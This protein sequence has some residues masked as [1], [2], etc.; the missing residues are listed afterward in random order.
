MSITVKS[1]GDRF[2]G[3][4]YSDWRGRRD[5]QRQRAGRVPHAPTQRDEDGF[6]VR[7]ALDARQP[8]RSPVRHQLQR[9]RPALEAEGVVL[10]QLSPER[11]VQ[12]HARHRRARALEADQQLHLQGHLPAQSQQ[13]GHR[14]PEQAREAAGDCATS[15][16]RRRSRR[17]ATRRRATTRGRSSG[18]ACSAAA[19]S[20]TCSPATGTTSSRC[21][22]PTTTGFT[23]DRGARAASTPRPTSVRRRRP[24]LATRIRS[25][26]SR[27]STSSLSYFKDGWDGSHDF[28]FGY[29]WK[30][31]RRNLFHD[32]PFDIFYRDLNSAR[33]SSSS[34]TTRRPRRSTTSSTT[35]AGSA[36]PGS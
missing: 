12:V 2:T 8:D 17:R 6:F 22:R 33:E 4:W 14:L 3:N 29:D 5:D 36:T 9:R 18:P 24:R 20:S 19:R 11:S 1:G 28:K 7:T 27:R 34:S 31:D 25:A 32:Q 21:G 23:T 15:A 16:R 35:P 10:L 13:P 26:T 30:R